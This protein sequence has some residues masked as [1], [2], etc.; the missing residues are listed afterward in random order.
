[1]VK[2]YSTKLTMCQGGHHDDGQGDVELRHQWEHNYDGKEDVE[3]GYQEVHHNDGQEDVELGHQRGHHD[4]GQGMYSW[5][6]KEDMIVQ[7]WF[8][9]ARDK[10]L[11]CFRYAFRA[12]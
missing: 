12:S 6:I 4:D 3:L 7:E 2:N 10:N 1:M 9:G 8:V 5:D 11:K